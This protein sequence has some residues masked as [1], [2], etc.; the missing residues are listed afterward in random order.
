MTQ[1]P[2]PPAGRPDLPRDYGIPQ[3]AE[4]LLPWS[5]VSEHMAKALHY[6]IATVGPH[7]HPHATPVWGMW[8]DDTFYFD[9]SPET[10]RGRNMAA[11]PNV[12]VH[13]E[14]ASEVVILHG[15]VE[16]L[17]GVDH[18]PLTLRLAP[19]YAEK[20][21]AQNYHPDPKQWDGGGL[22]VLHPRS[23]L[24]WSKFPDTVT[25]WVFNE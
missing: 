15:W 17:R 18:R 13:L 25:R 3:S 5:F 10:R 6:W 12:A 24:A 7:S 1:P 2:S 4:G 14:S 21:A 19:L 23:V 16:Q 11:N 20:Y 22:Y 8:L 9:G